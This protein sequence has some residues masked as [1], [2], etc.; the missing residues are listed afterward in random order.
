[1]RCPRRCA[2]GSGTDCDGHT[3]RRYHRLSSGEPAREFTV[4]IDDPRVLQN[5]VATDFARW[6]WPCKRYPDGLPRVELPREWPAVGTPAIAVL[7]GD[8]DVVSQLDLATVARLLHLSAGVVRVTERED[9]PTLLFRAAGSA[10]GRFPLELYLSARG[11]AGL[12]D[13][14]HFYDP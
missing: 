9:R 13:G 8:A 5:F 10:G 4:P 3:A 1:M 11:V 14:V 6:P 12:S 7:A 2:R